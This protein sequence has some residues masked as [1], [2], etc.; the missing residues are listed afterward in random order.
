[1]LQDEFELNKKQNRTTPTPVRM[2]GSRAHLQKVQIKTGTSVTKAEHSWGQYGRGYL[3]RDGVGKNNEK[4]LGF[5]VHRDDVDLGKEMSEWQQAQDRKYYHLVV[6]PEFSQKLDLPQYTRDLMAQAEKDLGQRLEWKAIAHYNTKTPH[7]HVI[8]RGRDEDGKELRLSTNYLQYGMVDRAR[9]LATQQMGYRLAA[10]E[11]QRRERTIDQ[12]KLTEVDRSILLRAG[13]TRRV[14][15]SQERPQ[16][17]AEE[18]RLN[19]EQRRLAYLSQRG[20]AREVAP[21]QWE[22]HQYLKHLTI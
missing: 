3:M 18:T 2:L 4:G 13:Q 9:E 6:S 12:E 1:M 20:L 15:L 10:Q 7:V 11:I 19:Q 14:D 8:V 17:V 16:N 5:D 22:I 21:R